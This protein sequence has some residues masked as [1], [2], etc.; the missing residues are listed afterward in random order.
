M[1]GTVRLIRH[2]NRPDAI[3]A[4]DAAITELEK[5]GVTVIS[6]KNTA[7]ADLVLAIGGDGTILSAAECARRDDVPLLGVNLGHMGFLAESSAEAFPQLMR[8]IATAE[9][10]VEDR[11][12]LDIEI[13]SPDGTIRYDWALNEAVLRHSDLAHPVH[14]VLAVDGQ[15]VSTYG[16]DGMIL[17]TPT[18]ST[19]YSFSA[20][21]PVV[22]PDTEAIVMTPLA[23]HGLFTRPL[24]VGPSSR[25]D[26]GVAEENW[27][28]SEV[29][30]DGLRR[31]P[32]PAGSTLAV[33]VGK[34]PV[35]LVRLDDTPFATRL[36]HKFTLP[37]GGW[38][39]GAHK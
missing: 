15:P 27:A 19:A 32:A 17:A 1:T 36:V 24:V 3:E 7:P 26:V 37:T 20:G 13:H 34:K 39:S 23:A 35:H 30:C 28:P 25:I 29:H 11:M 38:R 8:R 6:G 5:Y 33:T 22:W 9:Y 2:I 14:L 31:L 18:G 4:A 10:A 16:A 21:G 12:T